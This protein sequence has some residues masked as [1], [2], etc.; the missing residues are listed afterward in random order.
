MNKVINKMFCLLLY[1]TVF[2]ITD[3]VLINRKTI[4]L[5]VNEYDLKIKCL[6]KIV[7]KTL[8]LNIVC[9]KDAHFNLKS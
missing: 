2:H 8:K 1:E 5:F 7:D 9:G 3:I 4:K 6:L